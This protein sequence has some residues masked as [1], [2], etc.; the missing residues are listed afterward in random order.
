VHEVNCVSTVNFHFYL[1]ELWYHK[2]DES[3]E[4]KLLRSGS[5]TV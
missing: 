1:N 4:I 5:R 3:G 2:V